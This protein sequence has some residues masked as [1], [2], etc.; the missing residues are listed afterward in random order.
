MPPKVRVTQ[1]QI[2]DASIDIIRENG[3]ESLNARAIAD[4]LG[5]SVHPIFRVYKSMELLK[6]EVIKETEKLYNQRMFEAMKS[7]ENGFAQM[8]LTYIEF[9]KTEKNLFK[10]LFMTDAF[11]SKSMLDI[12][13]STEGDDEVIEMLSNM[14]GLSL[15]LSKELYAGTWLTTHGIASMYATNNCR[16]SDSEIKRLLENSYMG[17]VIKLRE[18]MGVKNEK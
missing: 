1:E 5:S 6:L 17:L 2:I 9:A 16:Y 18:E 14:T 7:T 15:E 13:G 12:V 8:G 10:L 4:K 3:I 11:E